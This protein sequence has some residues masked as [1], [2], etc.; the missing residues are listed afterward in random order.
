[1]A[2]LPSHGRIHRSN[3]LDPIARDIR[4]QLAENGRRRLDGDDISFIANPLASQ[5]GVVT[6]VRANIYEQVSRSQDIR[7]D[8]RNGRLPHAE[9]EDSRHDV[10]AKVALERRSEECP[11]R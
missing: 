9:K 4:N 5:N 11:A 8:P 10:I 1:L 6:N 3:V 2:A 7:D